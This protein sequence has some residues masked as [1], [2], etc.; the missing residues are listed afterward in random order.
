MS[1]S[2]NECPVPFDQQP[3]NE[4]LTLKQSWLFS[5]STYQINKYFYYGFI[6]FISLF[7]IIGIILL[8]IF[9]KFFNTW[10]IYFLD[11]LIIDFIFSII[12]MRL[13]LGWS[14]V[15]KRLLS[16]TIFYEES[17]WYDGQIWIKQA[18]ILMQDRLIGLYQVSPIVKKVKYSLFGFSIHLFFNLLLY[19]FL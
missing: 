2:K 15:M 3:L 17:G 6:F 16:A 13:Y 14:Y 4:Y 5:W 9:S 19:S 8:Y 11:N 7:I 18:D 12:L 1:L 10:K